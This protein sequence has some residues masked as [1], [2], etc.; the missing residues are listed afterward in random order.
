MKGIC[1][2]CKEEKELRMCIDG[3]GLSP[4]VCKE[5]SDLIIKAIESDRE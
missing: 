2:N 3:L 5:C 4:M 1:E